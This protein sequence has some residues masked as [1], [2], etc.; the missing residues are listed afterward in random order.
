M[1]DMIPALLL[2]AASMM[3]QHW[4]PLFSRW[5]LP[6]LAAY[7][8][9][10][11]TVGAILTWYQVAHG[12]AWWHYWLF[13]AVAGAADAAAYGID[14]LVTEYLDAAAHRGIATRMARRD[15]GGDGPAQ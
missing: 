2:C 10:V 11:A 14:W 12:W 7:T 9:G 1:T 3:A 15:R 5:R 4:F 13:Y 6:R 8:L